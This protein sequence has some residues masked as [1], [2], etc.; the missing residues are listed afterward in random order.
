MGLHPVELVLM[1]CAFYSTS[2][3]HYKKSLTQFLNDEM[4]N[5][6]S[7]TSEKIDIIEKQFKKSIQLIKHIW[8]DKAFNIYS[9]NEKTKKITRSNTFNQGLYQ[10]L[11]YWFIPFEKHDV[12]RHSDLIKEELLNLLIHN[13]EFRNALTGSGTN[14]PH[15]IRLKFD[16]WGNTIKGI[17]NYPQ[18][19]PRAFSYSLKEQLWNENDTCQICGQKISTI[20]DSEIDH[21]TCYWKGGKTIPENARLT[22][23]YCN[24]ARGG[25]D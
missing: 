4:K 9:I 15:N 16:I 17:I 23:R 19:E 5:N 25:R 11:S 20:E 2:P 10:I 1:F 6:K 18:N 3:E 21:I 14:S 22:H 12:I 13:E 7:I 24:R 8:G